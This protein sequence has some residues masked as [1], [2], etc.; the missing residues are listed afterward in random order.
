MY[1]E[2]GCRVEP[3]PV[4][5][6]CVRDAFWLPHRVLMADEGTIREIAGVIRGLRG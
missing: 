2:G 5:E 3:C 4:S 6:A 1:L